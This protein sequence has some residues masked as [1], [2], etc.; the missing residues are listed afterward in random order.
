MVR[1]FALLSALLMGCASEETPLNDDA[2]TPVDGAVTDVLSDVATDAGLDA[3]L[4]TP[5]PFD[6]GVDSGGDAGPPIM[7]DDGVQNGLET[8]VDCGGP[9]C[10]PCSPAPPVSAGALYVDPAGDDANDGSIMRPWRTV[11]HSLSELSP[12]DELVLRGG[13][14][15]ERRLVLSADGTRDNPVRVRG[16]PG[17]VAIIDASLQRFASADNDAWELVDATIGLYR[18]RESVPSGGY[19]GRFYEAGVAYN[20]VPYTEGEGDPMEN[21]SAQNESV[22]GE[23]R[24]VGPGFLWSGGRLFVRLTHLA[25]DTLNG[26]TFAI[27]SQQDPGRIALH[28]GDEEPMIRL[29]GSFVEIRNISFHFGRFGIRAT[30]S[31]TNLLFSDLTFE[32]PALAILLD[33][34]IR[35]VVA[36]RLRVQGGFPPWV[37]WTD[38]K[39]S[40][41]QLRPASHWSIRSAGV[42]GAGVSNIE[43]RDSLFERMWDGHVMSG[44][45]I[46]LHHNRYDQVYDDT[47]QL[48]SRSEEIEVDHNEILGAGPSHNGN[49][50]SARPGTVYIHHNV[51]DSSSVSLL[52]GKVDP[53][54]MLRLVY[55]GWRTHLPFPT[56]T[57]SMIGRGN[58]W[59]LYY[60][61]VL[62]H[63]AEHPRGC[64]ANQF[65]STNST[66]VAHEVYNNIFV[67]TS[68]GPLL[69]RC[70]VV[71]ATSSNYQIYDGNLYHRSVDSD[72]TL[73]TDFAGDDFD[74][75]AE[76][77]SS[78]AFAA[79]QAMTPGGW[80]ANGV[81]GDPGID[82]LFSTDPDGPAG[83]GAVPLPDL[84]PGERHDYR[85]AVSPR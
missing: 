51:I 8:M 28:I 68:G 85:G 63:G 13:R 40:D 60:N 33:D 48:G 54:N 24:Y 75:L 31:A 30:E 72:A 34:G 7:C 41:G 77:L 2:S 64:G 37:A 19:V 9:D 57:A 58:P 35:N 44:S 29:T 84:F 45:N 62:F 21:I 42:S 46:H 56:H 47:V 23:A 79:S 6:S 49:G 27:P 22:S 61:T 38:M 55:S 25:P 15:A 76:F 65:T 3:T 82:A 36:E 1:R 81:Q 66:G 12:G 20:L 53:G 26:E 32:T 74:S 5:A 50:T 80:E 10:D 18:S 69:G 39:G 16:M 11:A 71:G 70:E 52:W 14:Y 78:S 73:F 59:K 4:D 43:V 67:D 83:S 17:E